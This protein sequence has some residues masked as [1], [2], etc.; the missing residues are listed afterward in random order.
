MTAY[1]IDIFSQMM[2]RRLPFVVL[3]LATAC[4]RQQRE[5]HV[6]LDCNSIGYCTDASGKVAGHFLVS[7]NFEWP[8]YG[9]TQYGDR[10]SALDQIT[11]ANV[12]KLEVAWR[13]HTGEGAPEFKTRAPTA[14]EVTPLVFRGTMYLSTPLGRVFAVDPTSGQRRWVYDPQVDRTIYFGDFANRGV[15]LWL[16]S[17]A[18]AGSRCSLRIF[19]ATIDTRLISIDANTGTP[20]SDFG[21]QGSIQLRN[22][23]R[24]TPANAGRVRGDITTNGSRRRRCSWIRSRRQQS[25]RCR[26]RRGPRIRRAHRSVALDLASS[27]SGLH[28]S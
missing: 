5:A 4:A 25:H 27:S 21:Q 8:S 2:P 13:F 16:D 26:E 15:A 18:S 7:P 19:V 3:L 12:S 28:D 20:C 24:N 1:A 23:L 22:G 6:F 17:T 11:P 10:H 9:R 14:L